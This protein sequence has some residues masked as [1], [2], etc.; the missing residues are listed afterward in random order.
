MPMQGSKLQYSALV[1]AARRP[2]ILDPLAKAVGVTH[3]CLAPINGRPMLER[4]IEAVL[5]SDR[6]KHV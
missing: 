2:G 3:K 4:V 1:L 6:C 5:Q